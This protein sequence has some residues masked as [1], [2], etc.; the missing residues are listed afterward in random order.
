MKSRFFSKI[1]IAFNIVS[2]LQIQPIIL[3][4]L[5][6]IIA[7]DSGF[8]R[9]I[10]NDILSAQ[11]HICVV[12]TATNGKQA[13]EKTNLL[14]PDV[15]LLDL[16]MPDYDGIYALENIMAHCPTPVVVISGL[17]VTD[18]DAVFR[19]MQAG[20]YDFVCKPEGI[21]NTKIRSLSNQIIEKI[22]AAAQVDIPALKS[23]FKTHNAA[24]HTFDALLDYH[25]FLIGASTGGTGAIENIVQ[26]LPA[27]FPLPILIVQHMP[28]RFIESFAKR[29]D[30]L[31]DLPVRVAKNGE[32]IL[33]ATIYM[34]PGNQNTGIKFVQNQIEPV[35]FENKEV[36]P[37]YN[38]PSV[39]CLFESAALV[40]SGKAI[41]ALLTGMGRDGAKGLLNLSKKNAL[42][43][44]QDQQ[45][46][47][48]FGMPKAA[49]ELNAARHILSLDQISGFVVSALG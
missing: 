6:I 17:S 28:E 1:F 10:L 14:R 35:F 25:V 47:V 40:Y 7:D 15:V 9:L 48:V 5:K 26:D 45:S 31:I 16:N 27:N 46:S 33:P 19:A 22:E 39:D 29:L 34:M 18:P 44:A 37:E 49:I 38:N 30:L 8:M 24:V 21:L 23:N 42:T 12:D 41:A 3:Q 4:T 32:A 36:F 13:F 20:A 2:F 43:I 11:P